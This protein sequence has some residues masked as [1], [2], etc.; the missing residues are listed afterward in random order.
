MFPDQLRNGADNSRRRV[1]PGSSWQALQLLVCRASAALP[2]ALCR[3]HVGP[4]IRDQSANVTSN[5]ETANGRA[6]P[7][8]RR[9]CPHCASPPALRLGEGRAHQQRVI[10]RTLGRF[11]RSPEQI[12]PD[13]VGPFIVSILLALLFS[14]FRERRATGNQRRFA[15]ASERPAMSRGGMSPLNLLGRR[16]QKEI[17]VRRSLV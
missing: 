6:T 5:F 11:L 17:P 13:S 4:H 3:K 8:L 1:P 10:L 12:C 9:G 7:G 14:L 2:K 15:R 16:L